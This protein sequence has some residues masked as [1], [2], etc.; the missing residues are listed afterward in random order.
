MKRSVLN[1]KLMVRSWLL[2]VSAPGKDLVFA[3][4][5]LDLKFGVSG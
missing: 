1:F 4:V 5:M 2:P 3:S